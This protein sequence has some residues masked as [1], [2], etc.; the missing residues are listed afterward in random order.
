MGKIS[1][2]GLV[3][4]VLNTYS[5]VFFFNNRPFGFLL[6]VVTF[7]NF[8]AGLSGFVS[9]LASVLIARAM[10]FDERTINQGIFSFNSLLTGL[11]LGTFFDPGTAFFLILLLASLISTIISVNLSGWLGKYGLPFLSIPFVISLWIILAASGSLANLGLSQRNIF[12]M[13][14]MYALGGKALLDFF[15]TIENLPLNELSEVYLRSMS[16]IF[17]QDNILAGLLITI[18]LLA[19]SR[20]AFT[21]SLFGF[22]VAWLFAYIAG[23]ETTSM[24]FY[25]IGANYI[26]VAIAAGGFFTIPS[27]YSFLWVAIL[28]PLTSLLILFMNELAELIKLPLLSI[29]FSIVVISYLYFLI[30]RSKTGKLILTPL[31]NYSPE[32]N[33]Y[34]YSGSVDRT[35]GSYYLPLQLPFWGEWFVSQGYEGEFTHKDGWSK[36]LDFVIKD[37]NG[38]TYMGTGTSCHDY[39]CYGKPV[40]APANG[41]VYEIVDNVEDN[42]PGKVN[43][44]QN[45]GNTIIIKHS[46]N[47]YTQ[48][49]HLRQGY[50]K[51]KN[52][53]FVQKGDLIAFCGNSGR[54]PEPHIHFQVQNTQVPGAK[55]IAYPIAYYFLKNYG[56]EE[57]KSFSVPVEGNKVENIVT[58]N[59]LREAYDFQPGIVLR[60][61][62]EKN[63]QNIQWEVFTDIYNNKYLYCR[64][65]QS[66]AYFVNDGTMFYFTAFYGDRKSLLY[67][68]YLCS[69]KV[70]LGSYKNNIINDILPLNQINSYRLLRYFHDFASPFRQYMKAKFISRI[71]WTDAAVNPQTIRISSDIKVSYFSKTRDI[72]TGAILI[73]GDRIKEIS[74][75]SSKFRIWAQRTDT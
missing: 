7:F 54:S 22:V 4:A 25:N 20:I 16:S 8:S 5:V 60:F 42:E 26:L 1:G 55:P 6:M 53:D 41:E 44:A 48:I 75:V 45:W 46:S 31:Q 64:S 14:E 47:L 29:P 35:T 70:L 71:V 23:S 9:V 17:F 37:I 62:S 24:S 57:L 27:R 39:Y 13:N 18:A 59:L 40:I 38:K 58:T 3:P 56:K 12:W 33:L 19:C 28:I 50:F 43:T 66:Y 73:S 51:V 32:I 10:N 74:F 36:A 65:S 61:R 69:Y 30:L 67:Y 63:S 11:G 21:L 2:K 34:S 49:S 52:G 72:G 68:F 15:Q